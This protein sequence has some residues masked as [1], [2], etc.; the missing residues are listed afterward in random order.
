M[1]RLAREA[2]LARFSRDAMLHGYDTLYR[3]LARHEAPA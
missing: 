1:G 3:Q 2:V